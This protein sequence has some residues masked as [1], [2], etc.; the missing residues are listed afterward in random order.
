MALTTDDVPELIPEARPCMALWPIDRSVD[1]FR[2]P[3]T[4]DFTLLAT[5]EPTPEKL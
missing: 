4:A 3:E 1:E 2:E 5:D